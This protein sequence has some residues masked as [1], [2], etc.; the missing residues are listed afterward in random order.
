M[1]VLLI[2]TSEQTGGAAIAANRLMEALN[3]YGV[4]AKMLVRDKQT[5]RITVSSIPQSPML[6]AKFVWERAVIWLHNRLDRTNL[7][8]IDI[9]N[10][11]TDITRLPEFQEADVIHLHWVNQ[12][13]LSLADLERILNSGKRIIWTMHDQWCMTG[14]CHYSGSCT[15]Y[16]SECRQC[17]LLKSPS[18]TDL[19]YKVFQR[20]RQMLAHAHV[21]FV[22]CSQWIANLAQGSALLR[23]QR[24]VSIPNAISAHIFHPMPRAEARRQFSLPADRKLILFGGLK[25][26]DERKG[27][28]YL[29]E[30]T[31]ML[32]SDTGIVVVGKK[33][34]EM[35]SLFPLP[36]YSIPY[37]TDEHRM[38][39]LYAAVDAY[40]TPSLEDNLP[41]TIVEAM[42]CGTP[43]VGFNV[44]GIPEMIHHQHDG[45]VARYRDAADLAQG[46]R[47]VL[48]SNNQ[49]RLGQ[50]AHHTAHRY[51]EQAVAMKYIEEYEK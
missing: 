39:T 43:C 17:P 4:K 36:I 49:A 11:G 41:N 7:W 40:V 16:Q 22:G 47:Y 37:I 51:N 18:D 26:T 27:V 20:K 15:R 34:E 44:G 5:D 46:I 3:R 14:I 1:K 33:A 31:H 8:Q 38:A 10:T 13:F 42:S 21:T 45:Y 48:D 6:R 28:K 19:A 12:G 29:I 50:A 24:I 25:V 35:Q 32:P 30:S 9:A 23:H 2:N